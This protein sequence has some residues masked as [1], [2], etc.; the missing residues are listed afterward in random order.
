M[1]GF[2][3]SVVVELTGAPVNLSNPDFRLNIEVRDERTYIYH[4]WSGTCPEGC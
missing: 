4:E 1:A 3:G 2:C